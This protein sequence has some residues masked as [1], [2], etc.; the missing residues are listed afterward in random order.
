MMIH[1]IY[2]INTLFNS[3]QNGKCFKVCRENPNTYFT[4]N[5]FFPPGAGKDTICMQDN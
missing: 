4:F 5:H 3:P 1:H 2:M